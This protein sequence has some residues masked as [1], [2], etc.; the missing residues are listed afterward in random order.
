MARGAR[1]H[2]GARAA[3][4]RRPRGRTSPGSARRERNLGAGDHPIPFRTRKLSPASPRV[5]RRKAAGGQGVPLT[6]RAPDGAHRRG[7]AGPL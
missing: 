3:R 2:A 6:A 4:S 5:L 7:P 1:A